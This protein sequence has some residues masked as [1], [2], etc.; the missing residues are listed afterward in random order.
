MKRIIKFLTAILSVTLILSMFSGCTQNNEKYELAT[1]EELDPA[2]I[3]DYSTLKL[4]IDDTFTEISVLHASDNTNLNDSFFINELRRRTGLNVNVIAVPLSTIAEK[5]KVLMASK[6]EMPDIMDHVGGID[7]VNDFGKQGA[8]EEILQHID[9]LPNFKKL[10]YDE[11]DKYDTKGKIKNFLDGEGN[12]FMFPRYNI[13]RK[14]NHGF[15]YRKDIFD[16]HNIK[17]WTSTEEFLDVLRQLKKLY[18]DSTPFASKTGD[19]IFGNFTLNYGLD[20]M[21]GFQPY[22]DEDEKVW[23]MSCTDPKF[24]DCLDLVKTMFD[25]GLI[26]PEFVTATQPAWTAKMTQADKAFVTWDWIGRLDM[27]KEQTL[28]TVPDYDLRYAEPLEGKVI[29]LTNVLTGPAVKKG[30]NSILALKLLDYL[31]SDSGAMLS[32]L[33]IEGVTFNYNEKGKADYIGFE[34]GKAIG[35][36]DLE[37]KY[38]L[39]GPL[40][41]RYD[42]RCAYYNYTEKEQE[43]Q[44]MMTSK[45]DGFWPED[46]VLTFNEE[47]NKVIEKYMSELETAAREFA[48]KYVL[49]GNLSWNDWLEKA[50]KLGSEEIVKVYNSAQERYNK[51]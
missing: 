50:K 15:L 20:I 25:E 42:D 38:G 2:I 43:A 49:N 48:I 16:K 12:L 41:H 10:F 21:T 47:E 13:S 46:P 26:D 45:E 9:E 19:Q 30:K 35:I 34:E 3:G 36:T 32:T 17:M 24:K 14:V 44:D 51:L 7:E 18:P 37:A 39:C 33:G 5:A 4:P 22:Y 40:A 23:K 6:D 31:I 29:T 8:F 27:F 11:A 28:Q 1:K